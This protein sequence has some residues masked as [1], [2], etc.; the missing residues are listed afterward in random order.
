MKERIALPFLTKKGAVGMMLEE[1]IFNMAML[2][3]AMACV[4]WIEKQLIKVVIW[5]MKET[6]DYDKKDKENEKED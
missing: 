6:L 3:L 1:F 4:V 2:F 5:V